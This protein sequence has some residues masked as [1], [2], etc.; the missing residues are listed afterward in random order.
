MQTMAGIKADY[1]KGYGA[2][3]VKEEADLVVYDMTNKGAT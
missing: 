1:K 3:F 2:T